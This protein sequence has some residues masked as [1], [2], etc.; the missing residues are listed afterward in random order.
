MH[1][2]IVL[3]YP[4]IIHYTIIGLSVLSALAVSFRVALYIRKHFFDL[5]RKAHTWA[6]RGCIGL[7]CFFVI[8]H[9]VGAY[10]IHKGIIQGAFNPPAVAFGG[11]DE[12]HDQQL[13]MLAGAVDPWQ[14]K[15]QEPP[16]AEKVSASSVAAP[17][18]TH[19]PVVRQ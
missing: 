18:P 13:A 5:R 8:E 14:L 12:R 19:K 3:N 10:M 17:K 7:L 9:A 2:P 4:L 1:H 6:F 15:P 11:F 16:K